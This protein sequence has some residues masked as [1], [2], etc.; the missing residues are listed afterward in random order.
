MTTVAVL[1]AGKIGEALLSGLL[2]SGRAPEDL[3]F[4]ERYP[5]RCAELTK[6]Y[7]V[8]AV[9]V[10]SAVGPIASASKSWMWRTERLSSCWSTWPACAW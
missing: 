5:E 10:K 9:S 1:G 3:V 6:R 7:G 2:Q 4:T 8:R